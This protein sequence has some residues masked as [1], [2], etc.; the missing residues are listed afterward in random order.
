MLENVNC[1]VAAV[2]GGSLCLND[3]DW[4]LGEGLGGV[5]LVVLLS[6]S[7]LLHAKDTQTPSSRALLL[8]GVAGHQALVIAPG[9]EKERKAKQRGLTQLCIPSEVSWR[10]L[11]VHKSGWRHSQHPEGQETAQCSPRAPRREAD[12]QTE[13]WGLLV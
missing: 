8:A 4:H 3:P 9:G 10:F 1:V 13:L 12:L 2:L 6:L 7:I 11:V 5:G